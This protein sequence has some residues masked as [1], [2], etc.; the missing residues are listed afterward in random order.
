M[1]KDMLK[2]GLGGLALVL[3]YFLIFPLDREYIDVNGERT[4][5][6]NIFGSAQW[7]S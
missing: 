6:E 3:G 7:D 5:V 2:A 1:G 4:Q